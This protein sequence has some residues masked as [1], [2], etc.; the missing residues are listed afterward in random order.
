M[1]SMHLVTLGVRDFQRSLQFYRDGLGFLVYGEVD[2]EAEIV[3][4]R[5]RGTKLALYPYEELLHDIGIDEPPVK[6]VFSGITIAF[7]A[8]SRDEVDAVMLHAKGAGAKIV[9][10][11]EDTFW[12]GYSGY[13]ADPDGYI[14]EVAYGEMWEFDEKDMLVM[15]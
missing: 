7:N 3:F 8:K 15:E 4:F 2:G 1:N 13:F 10:E 14:W 12:G 11:P 6:P 9:K 5:T